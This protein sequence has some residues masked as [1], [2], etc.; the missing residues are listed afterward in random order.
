MVWEAKKYKPKSWKLLNMYWNRRYF[1]NNTIQNSF[2]WSFW[3]KAIIRTKTIK[4]YIHKQ[5]DI[6]G[7]RTPLKSFSQINIISFI[8]I[9][10]K[11]W[12]KFL[13]LTEMKFKYNLLIKNKFFFFN[14]FTFFVCTIIK[15]KHSF[16]NNLYSQEWYMATKNFEYFL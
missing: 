13:I 11:Y 3:N 5:T 12:K 6:F 7:K 14:I 10:Y 15:C 4:I 9:C 8:N 2:C 1:R 16:T